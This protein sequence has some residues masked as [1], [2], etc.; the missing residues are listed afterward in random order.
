MCDFENSAQPVRVSHCFG[1]LVP[2]KYNFDFYAFQK[3]YSPL[4][5]GLDQSTHELGRAKSI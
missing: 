5:L 2:P 1:R 4:E 3:T